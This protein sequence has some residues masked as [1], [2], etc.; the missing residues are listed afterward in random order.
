MAIRVY[1]PTTPGRRKAS[2]VDWKDLTQKKPEKKLTKRLKSK[3]GRGAGGRI[4]VRHRGGGHKRLYRMIDFKMQRFDIPGEV[5]AIEYDPNRSARIALVQ[6]EGGEKVY[7]LAA[8]GLKV[9]DKVISS[10]K[11][12]K[13]QTGSRMPLEFIPAGSRIHNMELQPGRG[14]SIVR[15]A[16]QS[17]T[18]MSLEGDT[19][20][21]KLPS[22]EVRLFKKGCMATVGA[23]SNPDHGLR[24][25]GKAGKKRWL[26]KRPH[27]LGKAMNP[28]DHPHGGGEGH[29]PVGM[30]GPK[31][32][33]GR[34][35]LGVRTRPKGKDSDKV[36]V[37]RR[38]S[39]RR[40]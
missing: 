40:K 32:K 21:V 28:V 23:V 39:K 30:K 6:Y 38:K 1:K 20:Q 34:P 18:L 14:G 3:A 2:V 17:A 9:G 27:V 29:Q 12:V 11:R 26:G 13:A 7:I 36:I 25:L 16:G 33:W 24:R 10:Q 4:A 19:A 35:A 37:S 22:G 8:Q 5:V 15:S 31:T